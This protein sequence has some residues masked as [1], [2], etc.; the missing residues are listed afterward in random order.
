MPSQPELI[1]GTAG[2][3][4]HGKTALV[5][6]LTG[7]DTDTL[8]EE[9]RRGISIDLGFAHLDLDGQ[10][11][12]IVDVPGHERFIKN[13]LA[14][15]GGIDLALLVVAADDSVMPQ[16]REHLMIL[17]LLGVTRGVIAL[18]KLD[19]AEASW[20]DLVEQEVRELTSGTFLENAPIIRTST[21]TG[22]GLDDLRSALAGVCETV[23]RAPEPAHGVPFRLAV[24]RSFVL[25]GLGTVV[26]GTVRSGRV[27]VGDELDWLPVGRTVRVRGIHSHGAG[28]ETATRGQRAALNIPAAHHTE[29]IRGHEVAS[30]GYLVPATLLTVRLNVL[31]T[32]PWPLKHRGRVRLYLGTSEIMAG[33]SLLGPKMLEPGETCVAQLYC[34]EPVVAVCRQP[35][36]IRAESPLWTIG[37]GSVLQPVAN[38]FS[39]RDEHAVRRLEPLESDDEYVRAAAAVYFNAARPLTGYDLCRDACVSPLRAG[40]VLARLDEQGITFVLGS[41]ASARRLHRDVYAELRD[42]VVDALRRFHHESPL[43]TAMPVVT[44]AQRLHYLD[45][46]AVLGVVRRLLG[47]NVLTGNDQAVAMADFAPVLTQAQQRLHGAIVGAF[48]AAGLT[49]PAVAELSRDLDVAEELLRPIIELC[50][51]QGHLARLGD[52]MFLHCDQEALARRRLEPELRASGGLAMSEIKSVLGV[53]RKYAVPICEYLDRIGFTRRV[54][55]RRVLA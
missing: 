18:T 43:M 3:I 20:I 6:A 38:R 10:R 40:P 37:G 30:P 51:D 39:R 14:G 17:Q 53:S 11:L 1:L 2:H 54:D 34:A 24:D 23:D 47:E 16:T 22:A 12:G 19:L 44:L 9:K 35:F 42:A 21:V 7:I 4:D 55:D 5:R 32:S 41:G 31:A 46:A 49:P 28:T 48:E 45:R 50:V 15:A 25:P 33:V 26:T 13:M 27:A 52:G 29:I 8:G 36:V